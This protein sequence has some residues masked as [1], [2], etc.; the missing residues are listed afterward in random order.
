MG[1]DDIDAAI[2]SLRELCAD[3]EL[4]AARH[5]ARRR[6]LGPFR[7]AAERQ[8]HAERDLAALARAGFSYRVARSVMAAKTPE[9]LEQEDLQ[10]D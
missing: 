1:K 6:R 3:P 5:F 2:A 9:D 4:A 10:P 7:A 8:R